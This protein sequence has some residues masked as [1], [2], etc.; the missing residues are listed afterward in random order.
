MRRDLD[1]LWEY[2]GVADS[3]NHANNWKLSFLL[4]QN[5][6]IDDIDEFLFGTLVFTFCNCL[7]IKQAFCMCVSDN[8]TY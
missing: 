8:L 3:L 2:T 1:S 5:D 6:F 4:I 7:I